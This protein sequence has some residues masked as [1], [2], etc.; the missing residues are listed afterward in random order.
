MKIFAK[1]SVEDEAQSKYHVVWDT[2][3][4]T[5]TMII[6]KLD[7]QRINWSFYNIWRCKKQPVEQIT[8]KQVY[9]LFLHQYYH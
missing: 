2:I 1:M 4:T 7:N 6:A 5:K 8:I 9:E 3:K